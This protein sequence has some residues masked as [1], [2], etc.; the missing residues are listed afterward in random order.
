MK[1]VAINCNIMH[2]YDISFC[3]INKNKDVFVNN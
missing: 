3:L 2:I 1:A